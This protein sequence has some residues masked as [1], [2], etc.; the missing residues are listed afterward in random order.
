MF[1]LNLVGRLRGCVK[2]KENKGNYGHHLNKTDKYLMT[3]L[4]DRND[5]VCKRDTKM[6]DCL[7]DLWGI[8]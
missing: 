7:V 1:N 2:V 6:N 8:Q 5:F 4:H 3:K